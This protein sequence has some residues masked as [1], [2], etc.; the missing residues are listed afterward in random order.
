MIVANYL[1]QPNT[2]CQNIASNEKIKK[3]E[4]ECLLSFLKWLELLKSS[5]VLVSPMAKGGNKWNQEE[6]LSTVISNIYRY[7]AVFR[8]FINEV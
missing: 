6:L 1:E 7:S 8:P 2:H 4:S 5:C 3:A